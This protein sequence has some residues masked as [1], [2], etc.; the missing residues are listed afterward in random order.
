MLSCS[1]RFG[2][3]LISRTRSGRQLL[4]VHDAATGLKRFVVARLVQL[5]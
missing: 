2:H 5:A 1:T 3:L 4:A